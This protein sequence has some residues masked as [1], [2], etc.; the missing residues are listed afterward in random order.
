MQKIFNIVV[1]EIR[2]IIPATIFFFIAFHIVAITK[3]LILEE[4]GITSAGVAIATIGALIVAKVILI[5]DKLPF[6]DRF[7]NKPLAYSV[8]WKLI[9][10]GAIVLLFRYIE[11]LIPMISKYGSVISANQHLV[12]ELPWPLFWAL[13]IWLLVTL[14]FYCSGTELVRAIGA[15]KLMEMFFGTQQT[16]IHNPV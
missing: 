1:H 11:E 7:H 8:I 14:L 5:A 12:A 10:Y 15:A 13:Q 6:I 9:I 3:T 2:E 16:V 4:Y